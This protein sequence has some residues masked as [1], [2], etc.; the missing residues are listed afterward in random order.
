VPCFGFIVLF[1]VLFLDVIEL[2]AL[3]LVLVLGFLGGAGDT[4]CEGSKDVGGIHRGGGE[5]ACGRNAWEDVVAVE[6]GAL[7][8]KFALIGGDGESCF[9]DLSLENSN[10]P[11]RK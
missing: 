6:T 5:G 1:R 3:E 2:L 8:H 7:F 10:A 11:E 9:P 4:R